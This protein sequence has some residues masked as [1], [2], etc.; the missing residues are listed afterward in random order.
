MGKIKK[1]LENE[2]VG[3]TQNTDIYPV[4]SVKAVY[5]EN[6]ERLDNIL[7][8]RGVVNISTNYNADH[9]AE[10]L[11][12]EQAIAKVPSKDRVLGFQGRFLSENG[13]K[14][15]VFIGDSIADWTNK[16]K[17]NN[18]LTG[19]DIVQELGE[20][21]DKVM[22]QKAIIGLSL[23]GNVSLKYIDTE[24]YPLMDGYVRENFE[25][26]PWN[27]CKTT[28]SGPSVKQGDIVLVYHEPNSLI[29]AASLVNKKAELYDKLDFLNPLLISGD[30]FVLSFG[31]AG[32][33]GTLIL[34]SVNNQIKKLKYAII[35]KS[36]AE[37]YCVLSQIIQALNEKPNRADIDYLKE[38]SLLGPLTFKEP[39][40]TK[41]ITGVYITENLVI[42]K[43]NQGIIYKDIED[44]KE[45][46]VV[47]VKNIYNNLLEPAALSSDD[48]DKFIGL[49]PKSFKNFSHYDEIEYTL[50]IY[51]VPQDG[52]LCLSCIRGKEDKMLKYVIVKK[53]YNNIFGTI[54]NALKSLQNDISY[55]QTQPSED[56]IIV[57]FEGDSI[58]EAW[59]D[60]YKGWALRSQGYLPSNF[61]CIN[62]GHSGFTTQ[63]IQD[64]RSILSS[65]KNR[66]GEH[67]DVVIFQPSLVNDGNFF[68]LGTF[69]ESYSET[70]EFPTNTYYGALDNICRY[71][72]T[73]Y[74]CVGIIIP[75]RV[76]NYS[77]SYNTERPEAILKVANKWGIPVLNLQTEAGFNI[78]NSVFIDKY[79]SY[80]SALEYDSTIGYKLDQ[81]VVYNGKIYKANIEISA[82]A[83]EFDE[84]KWIYLQDVTSSNKDSLHCNSYAYSI[85]APKVGAFVKYIAGAYI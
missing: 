6:N 68:K 62:N 31:V 28:S 46:D 44:V 8:R 27:G 30:N 9:I 54:M 4:T 64:R 70:E 73:N 51:L 57:S 10:I 42:N 61:K 24:L 37:S 33:D 65:L 45:G 47:L 11:T 77:A 84:S 18:Y 14:S 3:G 50:S 55:I 69:S 13:W 39:D 40:E 60:N 1:I 52:K 22:S 80:L 34:S 16:T 82:P 43:W 38:L 32:R 41:K 7:N 36:S 81:Q 66:I 23:L 75:Y 85:I 20:A 56:E 49:Y 83:G 78:G 79:G 74:K 67:Y 72:L 26:N 58:T 19:T 35:E 48:T 76:N 17:W 2:L 25:Y 53:E 21:E 5:D 59:H 12:L 15:Y 71:L 29:T 63:E